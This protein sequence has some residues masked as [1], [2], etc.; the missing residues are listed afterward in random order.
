MRGDRVGVDHAH[1]QAVLAAELPG[2]GVEPLPVLQPGAEA[3]LD[4]DLVGLVAPVRRLRQVQARIPAELFAAGV[5]IADLL[6]GR[7]LPGVVRDA[8]GMVGGQDLL[9]ELRDVLRV[10]AGVHAGEEP[11]ARGVRR[12]AAVPGEPVRPRV[13]EFLCGAV[14]VHARHDPQ[15]HLPRGVGELPQEVPVLEV[16]GAVLQREAAGVVG[17]NAARVDDDALDVV[18]TPIL[19]PEFDVADLGVNLRQVGLAPA[20]RRFIPFLFCHVFSPLFLPPLVRCPHLRHASRLRL[21]LVRRRWASFPTI[22]VLP[23]LVYF[24]RPRRAGAHGRAAVC[25]VHARG[26]C[27]THPGFV[28]GWFGAEASLPAL[29]VLPRLVYFVRPRRADAHGRAAVCGVHARGRCGTHPGFVSGWFGAAR[30][31]TAGGSTRCPRP[32]PGRPAGAAR[33]RSQASP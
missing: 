5:A 2:H 22:S 11:A 33:R 29:S 6:G 21:R 3:P 27:G 1:P 32:G 13:D 16:A 30:A 28:S 7:A 18:L 25:G 15:A 26:R 24:V 17:D 10:V 8:V 19:L 14:D 20:V 12:A 31:L 4:P 9:Q 23:R